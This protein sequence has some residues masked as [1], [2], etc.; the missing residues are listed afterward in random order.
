MQKALPLVL[1][2]AILTAGFFFAFQ[3]R[4]SATENSEKVSTE[5]QGQVEES[6][7]PETPPVESSFAEPP[8]EPWPHETGDVPATERATFGSLENGLRYVIVPNSE[9]P[10]RVSLRLH[11]DAGSLHEDDDQRGVAHF[12]EHMVFNG[13]ENFPDSKELI[14]RMQALGIGFGAHLNAYTSFDETVYMLDLPNLAEPTMDLAFTVMGDFADGALLEEEEIEKERGVILS[15][16]NSRDSVQTRLL[17]QQFGFLMPDSLITHRF[18]I[19][20]EEVIKS[21]VRERFTSFYEDY[22]IPRK[23]TFVVAGDIQ[24]EEIETRIKEIFGEMTNPKEIKPEP[25]L[26]EIPSE[27]GFRVAIFSDPEV[28]S[29]DLSLIQVKEAEVKSDSVAVRLAKQPLSVAHAM[30]SRRFS[31]LAK[32]EDSPIQSGNAS[33]GVWFQAMQYGAIDVTP[34]EG[35]WQDAV[36]VLEQ[37]FRRALEYG[38]NQSELDEIKAN[39]L[40]VYEQAVE[41]EE[42]IQSPNLAIQVVQTINELQS[43][44]SPATDLKIA[45]MGLD[46]LTPEAC[47]QALKEFWSNPDM[48]LVLTT[49]EEQEDTKATLA[50]LYEES[51]AQ[52]VEAPVEEAK[53]DFAYEKVGEPG[54]ILSQNRVEELDITQLVL[55]NQVRVNFKRTEF[56][57]NSVSL[58]ARFGSGNQTMPRDKESLHQL[59]SAVLNAGGLGKHSADDLRRI[60]AGRNVSASFG[61][62]DTAMTLSGSTTP[63]DLALQLQLMCAYLTDPGFRDEAIRQFQQALPILYQQL[64]HDLAGAQAKMSQWLYRDDPRYAIP[65]LEKALTYTTADVREWVLPQIQESYLE[66]SIVGDF[67]PETL[68]ELL[69]TTFGALPTRA[70]APESHPEAL[71][72]TLPETPQEQTFSYQSKIPKAAGMVL[73]ETRGIG[74]EIQHARRLNILADVLGNR[75][76]EKIREELGAT[77]SPQAASRPSD[78]FPEYGYLFGFSIAKPEELDTINEITA[79]LGATLGKE[80]ASASELERAL[81]PVIAQLEQVERDNGYW[82]RTVMA[83]SQQE[84]YR[85]E[86]AKGRNADYKSITLDD[87]N[88]LAAQY[89]TPNRVIQVQLVPEE[90]EATAEE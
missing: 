43:F 59:A 76:R 12:L 46:K 50:K 19:G 66:L 41:R 40:N 8:R 58:S 24:P 67:D 3:K 70:Y 57:K 18:P 63:D 37:E 29:E 25:E 56:S 33:K 31:V 88:E 65:S 27:T 68:P 23:M 77:Y 32:K 14:P 75:M 20:T 47:H 83:R 1:V 34:N 81:N 4:D 36:A 87:V 71:T 49:K 6:Q 42:T 13:S 48:T 78:T 9:P 79:E 7:V 51:Q 90:E 85:L 84:P 17:K 73:W 39:L 11:I 38:F 22:Y 89:L 62:G 28:P 82:L 26:G 30:L 52:A 55:S 45:K 21:A 2:I 80:G 16:K 60:L 64:K 86:W 10:K 54:T 15:E 53:V 44:S 69:T 61:I 35:R 74:K 5:E 72:L